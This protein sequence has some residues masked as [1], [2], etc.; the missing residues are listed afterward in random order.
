MAAARL[1]ALILTTEADVRW[2]SGFLT[3]FWQ[4]PTRPWFLVVP[5]SGKPVAVIPEIGRAAMARTWL[6]DIRT[7]ASPHPKD[8]GISLLADTLTGLAGASGRIGLPM[9]RETHLR[10]PLADFGRL[11]RA[12]PNARYADCTALLRGLR[13]RK[14]QREIEKIRHACQLAGQAFKR[15]PDIVHAG[16]PETEVF[17]AFRIACLEAG[18][19][20]VAYLVGGAGPGGYGD[21]I[22]PPSSRPLADGDVLILDTGC[23]VDGYFCDFDR[24]YAVGSVVPEVHEAHAIVWESTEAGLAAAKPGATAAD[25]YH[26]MAD[27]MP[28]TGSVGRLGHGLGMQLTEPPSLVPFDETVLEPGM[29]ITLEPGYDFAPGRAMVHEEVVVLGEDGAELLT[30]RAPRTLPVIG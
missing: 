1:D 11:Q 30:P 25:V 2:F 15:V 9:G 24:N 22:S 16:M 26:A 10:M 28:G 7:W 6:D 27:H 20:D 21:I 12:L 19:D 18:V 3:P 23:T 5:A 17:R 14:S 4:S 13:M 8:D 29:V